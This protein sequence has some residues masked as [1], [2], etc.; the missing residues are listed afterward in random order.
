MVDLLSGRVPGL[1]L[2]ALVALAAACAE[3]GERGARPATES[4][5]VATADGGGGR[6]AASTPAGDPIREEPVREISTD[7]ALATDP[8]AGTPARDASLRVVEE[9]KGY[10]L[11]GRPAEAAQRFERAT[12]IDPTNGFAYYYLGRARAEAGDRAGALGILEKAEALLGPYPEWR[13]H[14]ARLKASLGGA[15]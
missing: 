10:L 11:A 13:D 12:R 5:P 8:G 7:R 15:R 3:G 2:A 4:P 1:L 6:A 9:G 14:A